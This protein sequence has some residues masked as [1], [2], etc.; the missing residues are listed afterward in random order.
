M[1]VQTA[2]DPVKQNIK[3]SWTNRL[4][5]MLALVTAYIAIRCLSVSRISKIIVMA[6]RHCHENIHIEEANIAWEA[7]C[8]AISFF[9][10]RIACMELSLALTFFALS[11]GLLITWC[12]GVRIKPF[13][14]HAWVEIDDK[15]FCEP[16]HTE[17]IY[18][19]MIIC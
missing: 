1:S 19:K 3:L 11:K 18:R 5:G 6:K 15:P 16:E 10:G 7:V 4:R 17:Q 14:S 12:M 2:I 8:Q 13:G 9:P